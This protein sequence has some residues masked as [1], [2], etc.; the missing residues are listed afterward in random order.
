M[1]QTQDAELLAC[2]GTAVAREQGAQ[3]DPEKPDDQQKSSR[4]RTMLTA[5]FASAAVGYVLTT[6]DGRFMEANPAYCAL[7]GYTLDELREL[8][9]EQLIHPDDR[10]ENM[11]Q[12]K[13]MLSGEI[14]NFVIENRYR[15]KHGATVWVRKSVSVV[16]VEAGVP[17]GIMGLIEDVTARKEAEARLQA[18]MQAKEERHALLS[19]LLHS[20]S[21]GFC[22][23]DRERRYQMINSTLAEMNG[24]PAAD[25]IGRTYREIVPT[26]ADAV[27]PLFDQIMTT[28][29]AVP[30]FL[31]AGETAREPGKTRQWMES[32][33]PVT[34]SADHILGVG[35]LVHEVTEQSAAEEALRAA[36]DTFRHLVDNSPFGIYAVDADFRLMQVSAGAQKVFENVRPLIGRDFSE[37]LRII[38]PEP[39][40]T[41]VIG[42]FQ[43]TLQ[44]G[45]P[46]HAPGTVERRHDSDKVEAYDWKIE[47]VTLPDGRWGVVCHFYDLSE[48]RRFED[49]LGASE[50]RLRL[51][52]DAINGFIFDYDLETGFVFRSSG[53]QK[54]TGYAPEELPPTAE[55]WMSLMHPDDL[56]DL[57]AKLHDTHA[58][59]MTYQSEYRIRH[60]D[61]RY[62][63]VFE[64][65]Q[66]VRDSEEKPLRIAGT[67]V[68]VTLQKLAQQEIADLNTRLQRAMAETHHRTKNNLQILSAL[69]AT[70]LPDS[71]AQTVPVAA[72]LRISQHIHTLAALHD[73][74]TLQSK[75]QPDHDKVSLKSALQKLSSLLQ[76]TTGERKIKIHADEMD[77]TLKQSASFMLLVN[78]LV[79]NALKHGKGDIEITLT[80]L[81]KELGDG[82]AWRARLEVCDDGPGFPADFDSRK[83]AHTGLELIDSL[84]RWD[85]YG[86]I[87]YTNRPEGGGRV[88]VT[89]PV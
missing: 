26:L 4:E 71:E 67:T 9:F 64:Q 68:D 47:R 33:Y 54:L 23:F 1:C 70:Q 73:L 65:G 30:E 74:L 72:L 14:S 56:S 3:D 31:L 7:T 48:R 6:F 39:F 43:H 44:T 15:H 32:W 11:A 61:G 58:N 82:G 50:A 69:I 81:S 17:Q 80:R 12:I 36:H 38:W 18:E 24:I 27:D 89:F 63:F 49:A 59:A 75:F 62:I 66:I 87:T 22:F 40:A 57:Q 2:S 29:K 20:A 88:I 86:Q 78:E 60:R 45:E 5:A 42:L 35:V 79:S 84:G 85:L 13:R 55:G 16:E 8:T 21:L 34:N 41:H 37:V 19:S 10:A 76:S 53:L 28:R 51:A 46:Y 77:A 52:L 83:A 25:H